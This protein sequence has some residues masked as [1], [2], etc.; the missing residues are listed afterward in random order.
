M[1]AYFLPV[2]AWLVGTYLWHRRREGGAA[3]GVRAI[4]VTFGNTVQLGIPLSAAIFGEQGL[5]LHIALTSIHALILL[6][7][8]T[9]LVERDLAQ[10]RGLAG[11]A[12]ASRCA[13]P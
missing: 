3:P 2:S 11:A 1:L 6:S 7:M 9:A 13:T 4:T 8:A 5:A 10:R 12:R